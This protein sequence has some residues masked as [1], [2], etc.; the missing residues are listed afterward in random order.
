MYVYVGVVWVVWVCW[1][2]GLYLG[3]GVVSCT[4][5]WVWCGHVG[6]VW[7]GVGWE[8]NNRILPGI[9]LKFANFQKHYVRLP[10]CTFA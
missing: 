10:V 7:V 4:C 1:G 6:V 5:M 3:G 2:P 9:F 8:G